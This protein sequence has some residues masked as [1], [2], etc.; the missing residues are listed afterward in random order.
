MRVVTF[1]EAM[2][3]F[4][5][6]I[7][8]SLEKAER[9]DVEIAGAEANVAIALARLGLNVAW[10]SRLPRNA[11]G[12]RVAAKIREHGVDTS[13]V[14]WTDEGRVGLYFTEFGAVPRR[15]HVIYDRAGSSFA[16]MSPAELD[17]G[18]LDGCDLLHL[19]G[20]TP[21]LS[22]GCLEM[23]KMLV[24]AAAG[25]GI[26]VSFDVNF[27]GKLWSADAA[28][29]ALE[30]VLPLVQFLFVSS[31]DA[32]MVLRVDDTPKE[33]AC[34]LGRCYPAAE[35]VLTA[36]EDGAWMWDGSL[37]YRSA[38]PSTVMDRIGR[39][40]AFCAGYLYGRLEAADPEFALACGTAVASLAQTFEGDI[41]WITREDVVAL[42]TD[43]AAQ[44]YR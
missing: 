34:A 20:I 9:Y 39:G 43:S 6:P 12:R 25:R 32:S 40:D 42:A 15:P 26:A 37:H 13:R 29:T 4:N 18:I 44:R 19:T 2:L 7:G 31:A 11:L 22:A 14:V 16:S 23:T 17:L 5:P 28:R 27:R 30:N 1:G 10:L 38:V 41:A 33:Q 8:S 21:A 3:R 24:E 35:V 36:G